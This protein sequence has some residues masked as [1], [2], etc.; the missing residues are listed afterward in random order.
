[1]TIPAEVTQG[2]VVDGLNRVPPN[3]DDGGLEVPM[4]VRRKSVRGCFL[5]GHVRRARSTLGEGSGGQSTPGSRDATVLKGS[6]VTVLLPLHP[7]SESTIPR[8]RYK[9]RWS[10]VTGYLS[11]PLH[12]GPFRTRETLD[13]GLGAWGLRTCMDTGFPPPLS[14]TRTFPGC[15]NTGG[16]DGGVEDGPE[17]SVNPRRRYPTKDYRF[18]SHLDRESGEWKSFDMSG[19]V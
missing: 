17:S 14:P 4:L 15:G 1:M 3:T 19:L 5:E 11:R 8:F 6:S 18:G 9:N 16:K 7:K 13:D 12:S 2:L 10:R